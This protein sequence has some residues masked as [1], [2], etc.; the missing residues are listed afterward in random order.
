M[1]T[2]PELLF[3]FV[4]MFSVGAFAGF[5]V[6]YRVAYQTHRD[7]IERLYDRQNEIMGV[8]YNA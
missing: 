3:A 4:T 5:V 2:L 8:K 6:G 7:L 1:P